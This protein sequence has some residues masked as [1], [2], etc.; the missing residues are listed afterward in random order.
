MV[1]LQA[2]LSG[3]GMGGLKVREDPKLVGT[4][5]EGPL[6]R[7]QVPFYQTLGQTLADKRITVD[8]FA[9]PQPNAYMD[10]ATL[11]MVA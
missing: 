5:K 7:P 3:L 1:V 4:D 9:F 10:I 2:S 8:I 6:F 11:G